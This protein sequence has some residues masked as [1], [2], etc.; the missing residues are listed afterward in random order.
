MPRIGAPGVRGS[1]IIR[2]KDFATVERGY[3]DLQRVSLG[4]PI[5][6]MGMMVDNAIVVADGF[7]VTVALLFSWLRSQ[8]A[9]RLSQLSQL[10]NDNPLN[11]LQWSSFYIQATPLCSRSRSEN[12]DR[13]EET[14][15]A[16]CGNA[17]D[18]E[19][20]RPCANHC[21]TLGVDHRG[22]DGVKTARQITQLDAQTVTGLDLLTVFAIHI[23]PD[24]VTGHEFG[25]KRQAYCN[26]AVVGP[27][28]FTTGRADDGKF[29]VYGAYIVLLLRGARLPGH[30][31]QADGLGGL[32]LDLPGIRPRL[33]GKID[34]SIGTDPLVHLRTG[35]RTDEYHK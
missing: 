22:F 33:I 17:Q 19:A 26:V 35:C 18:V 13:S 14:S 23:Q 21:I 11:Q 8:T 32:Y 24:S 30:W 20:D 27:D 25:L 29:A 16:A 3:I 4:A 28:T 1:D 2:I 5:I 12:S 34:L 10:S 6:A 9:T 31:W 15:A 7:V